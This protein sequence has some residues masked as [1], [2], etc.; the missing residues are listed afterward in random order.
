[1]ILLPPPVCVYARRFNSS[2]PGNVEHGAVP[3][4]PVQWA[5]LLST[6]DCSANTVLHIVDS[7]AVRHSSNTIL[8]LCSYSAVSITKTV[9]QYGHQWPGAPQ[10]PPP[11][12]HGISTAHILILT[13]QPS[14]QL[15]A[16]RGK[17]PVASGGFVYFTRGLGG[18]IERKMLGASFCL[19]CPCGNFGLKGLI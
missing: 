9:C 14:S 5:V 6:V 8:G 4:H 13:F 7:S 11:H 3:G 1:M 2:A 17:S 16:G 10:A 18:S 12:K 15:R 19:R